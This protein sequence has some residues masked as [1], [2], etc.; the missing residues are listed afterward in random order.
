[1]SKMDLRQLEFRYSACGPFIK[2]KER[3][4][5][6][7]ET[8]DSQYIYQK[9][10]DKNYFQHDIACWDF[11]HY[12]LTKRKVF[13]ITSRDKAFNIAKNPKFDGYHI[14]RRR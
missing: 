12:D 2:N 14:N 5:K 6:F 8:R 11:N 3:K 10:L 4:E 9:Q 13:D 1:M 7:K